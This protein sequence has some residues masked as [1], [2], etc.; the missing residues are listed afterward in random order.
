MASGSTTSSIVVPWSEVLGPGV[1]ALAELALHH[2]GGAQRSWSSREE[3]VEELRRRLRPF[4]PEGELKKILDPIADPAAAQLPGWLVDVVS[5]VPVLG[6]LIKSLDTAGAAG[7]TPDVATALLGP[8]IDFF[9][10]MVESLLTRIFGAQATVNIDRTG[11]LFAWVGSLQDIITDEARLTS[12]PLSFADVL[13]YENRI[14]GTH[15][16]LI[17]AS[18]LFSITVEVISLGQVDAFAGLLINLIDGAV[19]DVDKI[20]SSQLARRAV[21]DPFEAGYARIHRHKEIS[22]SEAEEAF[23]LGL[24]DETQLVEALV[25]G[26]YTDRAIQ[27]KV[28]LARVRALNQAGVFPIRTKF[29]SPSALASAL[30]AKILT[31]EEFLLELARQGYDDFALEVLYALAKLKKA[32]AAPAGV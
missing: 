23:A 8:A 13:K 28:T 25:V 1:Q 7:Q 27:D 2:P 30:A 11:D 31:D 21:A 6:P 16:I 17:L 12:G 4:M 32:P 22:T 29:V 19:G 5:G 9:K 26:G 14:S 15:T 3:L 18:F 24:L 20:V 10:A